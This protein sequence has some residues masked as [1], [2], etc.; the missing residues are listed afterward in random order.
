MNVKAS[1]IAALAMVL[2]FPS[3][4]KGHDKKKSS[5]VGML[6][7]MQSI[8]C[9][10]KERGLT[11]LGAMVGSIGVT[12]VNSDEKLC[13]QYLLRT[14]DMDYHIRPLDKKHAVVLSVGHEAEF[15]FKKDRMFL[16]VVDSDKKAKPFQIVAMQPTNQS[17]STA[18]HPPDR[19][20][21]DKPADYRPPANSGTNPALNAGGMPSAPATDHPPQ[22]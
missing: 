4:A 8:P 10:A 16:R 20:V 15:K 2:V 12:H 5:Q 17:N 6:E 1:L 9:G 11:G 13:P 19:P 3:A 21:D 22:P 14:D 7:S 18:Y